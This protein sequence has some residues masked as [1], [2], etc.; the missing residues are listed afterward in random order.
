MMDKQENGTQEAECEA[1]RR[2]CRGGTLLFVPVRLSLAAVRPRWPRPRQPVLD[3]EFISIPGFAKQAH[4]HLDDPSD[5]GRVYPQPV[6]E[7]VFDQRWSFPSQARC[8]HWASA[9]TDADRLRVL[10]VEIWRYASSE[11]REQIDLTPG[12]ILRGR[13]AIAVIHLDRAVEP[14]ELG[15][16]TS[17]ASNDAVAAEINGHLGSFAYLIPESFRSAVWKHQR[18]ERSQR[19]PYRAFGE[20]AGDQ[21]SQRPTCAAW[22]G[23]PPQSVPPRRRRRRD[24]WHLEVQGEVARDPRCC[25]SDPGASTILPEQIP[26][27]SRTL[28][29]STE[30]PFVVVFAPGSATVAS[31]A[32]LLGRPEPQP[33]VHDRDTAVLSHAGRATA[34]FSDA[35]AVSY[36]GQT[37]LAPYSPANR[38]CWAI[39]AF[40]TDAVMLR[41]AQRLYFED[42]S[43]RLRAVDATT[44]PAQALA[45]HR[46]ILQHRARLW[47]PRLAREPWVDVLDRQLAEVWNLP[48]IARET[49][50]ETDQ[51]AAE[52][53]QEQTRRLTWFLAALAFFTLAAQVPA[54]LRSESL[55]EFGLLAGSLTIVLALLVWV[56]RYP[57]RSR[58]RPR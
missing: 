58:R 45:L 15:W 2:S 14:G 46:D 30:M 9:Q 42:A 21:S 4:P 18:H 44:H 3:D 54:A 34:V 53:E 28:A 20:R 6:L 27:G 31:A 57:R 25:C 35:M 50:E 24:A 55:L 10:V 19:R 56:I 5:R 7:T 16:V 26:L 41:C 49:F 48:D 40:L 52:A 29:E 51:L 17:R 22:N 36:E 8:S 32:D 38:T 13:D 33:A 47:W 1:C 23:S 43:T 37:K 11:F 39:R 12:R